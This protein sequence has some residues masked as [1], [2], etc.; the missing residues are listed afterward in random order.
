MKNSLS[1]VASALV[2]AGCLTTEVAKKSEAEPVAST[3]SGTPA[4]AAGT[5]TPAAAPAASTAAAAPCAPGTPAKG[6]TAASKRKLAAKGKQ[7]AAK[8]K[9]EAAPCA[10]VAAAPAAEAKPAPADTAADAKGKTADASAGGKREVKG[11]ND[12]TGYIQGMPASGSKF[13]K[14]KIGMGAK[15]VTD[16]VG[17]PTDQQSHVTG[18]AWIP[19]YAGSGQYET[20]YYYKG[21]GRLLFAGNGGFSTGTGLIGIEHDASERGYAR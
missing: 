18:K 14:L 17:A 2:L 13:G 11:L 9:A 7:P 6:K 4:A 16:L 19:F 3:A 21:I 8:D 1:V 5:S 15:E 12:W 20:L 10:N